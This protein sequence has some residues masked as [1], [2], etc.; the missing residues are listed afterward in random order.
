MRQIT[1]NRIGRIGIIVLFLA[2][3]VWVPHHLG[4]EHHGQGFDHHH[5]QEHN[6][7]LEDISHSH[8]D[9][10]PHSAQDHELSTAHFGK[11]ATSVCPP[12][13]AVCSAIENV[14]PQPN[15]GTWLLPDDRP[16][17]KMEPRL[18]CQPRAP[19]FL[20]VV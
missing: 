20:F 19:P 5:S 2:V 16:P 1:Q 12:L 14:F 13:L 17:P 3:Q 6:S 11:T 18:R 9:H 4:S 7:E 10:S 15:L 8:D